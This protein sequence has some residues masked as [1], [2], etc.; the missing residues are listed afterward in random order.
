P[1]VWESL[2]PFAQELA[3]KR[4]QAAVPRIARELVDGLRENVETVVDL[5]RIA[6][7]RLADPDRMVR[8]VRAE[9]G[10][11]LRF[12]TW[13]ALGI[14]LAAGIVEAAMLALTGWPALLPLCGAAIGAGAGWL[15]VE[16]VLCPREPRSLLGRVTVRGSVHRRRAAVARAYGELIAEEVLTPEVLL[17]AL[18]HGT[19]SWRA[20]EVLARIV[21]ELVEEQVRAFRPLVAATIGV[22]RVPAMKRTAAARAL[23]AIPDTVRRAHRYLA[24][25]MAVGAM[26]DERVRGLP[27]A[28]F[29]LLM[30]PPVRASRPALLAFAAVAGA[31]VGFLQLLL[32]LG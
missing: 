6:T 16:L 28:E 4:L 27:P 20:R 29:E 7:R 32:P 19:G 2:P 23:A 31:A 10:P 8:L 13:A 3:V 9:S 30:R 25:A 22:D 14:G 17:D 24:D 21:D 5:R 18:A 11:D 12:T 1:G 15:A 26:V